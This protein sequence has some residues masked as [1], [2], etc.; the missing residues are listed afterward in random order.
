MKLQLAL[1]RLTKKECLHI[2]EETKDVVDI[3]EIGTGVIKEY[4]MDFIREIKTVFP[5]VT[6][7]AD[8]KTC[9][10]GGAETTQAFE[11]GAEMTT[12][13]A[14]SS[15]ET[16]TASLDVAAR[17]GKSVVI[18]LLGVNDSKQVERLRIL[19]AKCLSLHI[20]KDTQKGDQDFQSLFR[21]LPLDHTFKTWVAGGLNVQTI[22][23]II[24]EQPDIAIV[25]S[26]ITK[27]EKPRV[28]ALKLK[29]MIATQ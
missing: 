24:A 27:A 26:A 9:D 17:Y 2:I 22:E 28:V 1:D 13:M 18:D 25:G 5:A 12:V 8:M 4:G 21:I 10:A 14:F 11:A 7:L 19:G 15:N 6:L 20:G 29:E 23:T 16:I 3:V